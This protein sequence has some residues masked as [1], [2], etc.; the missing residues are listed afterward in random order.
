M[1]SP[2]K[3]SSWIYP[4][5]WVAFAVYLLLVIY[6]VFAA[7]RR[8]LHTPDEFRTFVNFIPLKH[9]LPLKNIRLFSWREYYDLI[10]NVFGNIALF[11]P[12]PAFLRFLFNIKSDRAIIFI[13]LLASTAI[14][15]LQYI[16][17]VGIADVDDI[18]LNTFGALLGVLAVNKLRG[19]IL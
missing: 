12:L 14:E 2:K 13:A 4:L 5:L 6:I 9:L 18:L 11:A 7:R 16:I 17:G 3:T 1:I 15:T 19:F 8:Q 10:E